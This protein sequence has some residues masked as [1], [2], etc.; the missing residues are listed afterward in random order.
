MQ[1]KFCF[2]SISVNKYYIY[3]TGT[4]FVIYYKVINI[5]WYVQKGKNGTHWREVNNLDLQIRMWI[6]YCKAHAQLHKHVHRKNSKGENNKMLK[7]NKR[8]AQ[9]GTIKRRENLSSNQKVKDIT[10]G[11]YM[12]ITHLVSCQL[13]KK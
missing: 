5:N 1:Q 4:K 12:E 6:Y 7:F 11:L 3:I 8:W 10:K 9:R 13:T 2:W